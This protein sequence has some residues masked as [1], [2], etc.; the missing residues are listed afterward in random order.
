MVINDLRELD[1][2]LECLSN[3]PAYFDTPIPLERCDVEVFREECTVT[4]R[5]YF[6]RLR[7]LELGESWFGDEPRYLI[8]NNQRRLYLPD[9]PVVSIEPHRGFAD[10]G[11]VCLDRAANFAFV[12]DSINNKRPPTRRPSTSESTP[13]WGGPRSAGWLAQLGSYGRLQIPPPPTSGIIRA[14]AEGTLDQRPSSR[15]SVRGPGLSA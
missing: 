3:P 7:D 12:E 5:S 13:D 8:A 6:V 1:V 15:R 10:D 2:A 11:P 14:Q 9:R 4:C